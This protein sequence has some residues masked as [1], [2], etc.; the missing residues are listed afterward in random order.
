MVLI[1]SCFKMT[2]DTNRNFIIQRIPQSCRSLVDIFT[3]NEQECQLSAADRWLL[4]ATSSHLG[5]DEFIWNEF[6]MD[7]AHSYPVIQ[8]DSLIV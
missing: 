7:L 2:D 8:D 1:V 4:E 3:R 6:L 5:Q